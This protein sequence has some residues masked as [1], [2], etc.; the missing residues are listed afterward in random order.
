MTSSYR[1]CSVHPYLTMD[2]LAEFWR[3]HR[4]T[5]W[6]WVQA[7][8][9]RPQPGGRIPTAVLYA[10]AGQPFP[11]PPPPPPPPPRVITLNPG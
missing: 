2:D 11:A 1:I 7:D 9:V 5:A 6:R 8:G 3:V 10:W 4:T